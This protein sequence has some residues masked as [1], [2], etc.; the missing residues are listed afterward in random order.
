MKYSK[1]RKKIPFMFALSANAIVHSIGYSTWIT[2]DMLTRDDSIKIE[3]TTR[4]PVCYIQDEPTIKYMTIEKALEV[5]NKTATSA[6][7]KTVVVIP[8][9]STD[10]VTPWYVISQPCTI[11]EY[12]T[13]S[14][15][16][17]E[18]VSDCETD[19]TQY[20]SKS[21][22]A[23]ADSESTYK[24]N[25]KSN[26]GLNSTLTVKGKLN[27]CGKVG[28]TALRPSGQTSSY[29]AQLSLFDNAKITCEDN[30]KISCLGYIKEWYSKQANN[31]KRTLTQSNDSKI[32]M[33]GNSS[34][35][36][37]GVIYDYYGGTFSLAAYS[38]AGSFPFTSFD[39][40]NVQSLMEFSYGSSIIAY[41]QVYA[42]SKANCFE[43][44]VVGPDTNYLFVMSENS[45]FT[46]KYNSISAKFSNAY[47]SNGYTSDKWNTMSMKVET[48][49]IDVNSITVDDIKSENYYLPINFKYNIAVKNGATLNFLNSA[50][51]MSGSRLIVEKGGTLNFQKEIL[52]HQTFNLIGTERFN[53]SDTATTTNVTS[54]TYPFPSDDNIKKKYSSTD[55]GAY[56]LNNGTINISGKFG[57]FITAGSDGATL[58]ISD[59]F[60][61]HASDNSI[62]FDGYKS[63]DYL[64]YRNVDG[65]A[66][67]MIG[68]ESVRKLFTSGTYVARD[69]Y[70]SGTG[71]DSVDESKIEII[72]DLKKGVP[73]CILPTAL[74]LM[75]D[76][77]CKEAGLIRQ[78][79]MVIAFNHEIGEFQPS[80]VLLN[81][82]QDV[83]PKLYDILHLEFDNGKS[84][85]LIYEHGYFDLDENK[86]VYIGLDN[87]QNYIG[88]RFVFVDNKLNRSFGK[89][90]KTSIVPTYTKLAAISTA[91]YLNT[92]I[93]D[94]LS[95]EGA[96]NGL[97]NIFEYNPDTLAFD[98]EKKQKDIDKYGLL[99]YEYFKDYF[100]KEIYDLLPCKYL[101]VSIGKGLINWDIIEYYIAKWKNQ[102]MQIIK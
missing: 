58:S 78:G 68:S 64:T 34:I 86:Y 18:S 36:M 20:Q 41:A 61:N 80:M 98:K 19:R 85:D 66:N 4:Q 3:K 95:V 83:P 53:N 9:V 72:G 97:F 65:Y 35:E 49:T 1:Q 101:G 2:G 47:G 6:E 27:I 32:V 99:D 40:P 46:F 28:S 16:Y 22:T 87:Y 93:D 62:I 90:V 42:S 12:V 44:N 70:W 84:T 37:P 29:Y 11:G 30:G 100:P 54:E 10:Y 23:F 82:H 15:T 69:G 5:A 60:T 91:K 45:K 24:T 38:N 102:L 25:L 96:L 31:E 59:G 56:L 74:V 92:I 77:T 76:G 13:L 67:G 8:H 57:G 43:M 7:E 71:G 21:I 81:D 33:T 88:H 14:I 50:K 55:A 26:I 89:L 73:L 63:H 17:D 75:A 51:F 52:F 39:F 94:T 79:D 48:G